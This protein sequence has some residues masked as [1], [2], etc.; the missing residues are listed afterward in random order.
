MHWG[1][2]RLVIVPT[3]LLLFITFSSLVYAA[4][5]HADA[6][7]GEAY[8]T[9]GFDSTVEMAFGASSNF[10]PM[11]ILMRVLFG[12]AVVI[13]LFIFVGKALSRY[14]GIQ[15]GRGGQLAVVDALPLA[16]GK[17]LYLVRAGKRQFLLGVSSQQITVLQELSSDDLPPLA[18]PASEA[19]SDS[20]PF[21]TLLVK[22]TG[23]T[24][25]KRQSANLWQE[26]TAAVHQSIA[27]LRHRSSR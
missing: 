3:L 17:G 16:P 14:L 18:T 26:A 25:G 8:E 22:A 24:T 19:I 20:E 21:Q 11:R 12:L 6:M 2:L 27:R 4:T 9:P 23:K 1:T 5:P 10:S 13:V 15:R 7:A